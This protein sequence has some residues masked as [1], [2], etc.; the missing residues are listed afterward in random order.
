[1]NIKFFNLLL[2]VLV[3][4]TSFS[5]FAEKPKNI[6]FQSGQQSTLNINKN[7]KQ[8]AVLKFKNL[9][10]NR[11]KYSFLAE[12][13]PSLIESRLRR[14]KD[15][16]IQERRHLVKVLKE[17]DLGQ[18]GLFETEKQ[19]E[20]AKLLQADFIISGSFNVANV[21]SVNYRL[22]N[23]ITGKVVFIGN[24]QA[25]GSQLMLDIEKT[26]G[27]VVA[28]IL[29]KRSS[30][31]SVKSNPSHAKIYLNGN[32]I[33]KSPIVKYP[34]VKGKYTIES[35]KDNYTHGLKKISIR[36]N[37]KATSQLQM[38]FKGY[39]IYKNRFYFDF[40]M[41]SYNFDI[42]NYSNTPPFQFTY[43]RILN[44]FLL[45]IFFRTNHYSR[46]HD[47]SV[48][49][50][51]IEEKRNYSFY[52]TGVRLGYHYLIDPRYLAIVP[53]FSMGYSSMTDEAEFGSK[54]EPPYKINYG[55]VQ[56]GF[57]LGFDI[58]PGNFLGINAEI[59]YLP[60]RKIISYDGEFNPYG[61]KLFNEVSL[62]TSEISFTLGVRFS[63]GVPLMKKLQNY[64]SK[65]SQKY[66]YS[67][68]DKKQS[69]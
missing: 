57:H 55:F 7:K 1:V 56:V 24:I 23:A 5:V 15:I 14:E 65:K 35:I 32:F 39:E 64:M 13:I 22:V 62:Q 45:G 27:M 36:E 18:T 26:A 63:F 68:K 6:D 8:I 46:T 4:F 19:V 33:G 51:I 66:Y 38:F 40:T 17:I 29:G 12:Q 48:F 9:S 28:E 53:K 58:F 34:V 10:Q 44:H 69:K 47:V 42:T 60:R 67:H 21:T 2:L 3:F 52:Y 59:N 54:S 25:T 50:T 16:Q 37:E 43:E 31:L 20:M 49:N 41:A 11:S 30:F 61:E